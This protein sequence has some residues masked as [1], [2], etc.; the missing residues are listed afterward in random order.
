VTHPKPPE[1]HGIE[2]MLGLADAGQ[3]L[4]LVQQELKSLVETLT[5]HAQGFG[6]AT[7]KIALSITLTADRTGQIDMVAEHKITEPKMPKAKGSA[8][9]IDGG[10]LTV[11]N[12]FQRRMEIREVGDGRRELRSPSN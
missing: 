12:P 2:Q 5:I 6:K 3:Y 9:A 1:I 4:P 8:W 11:V 10:G 7:G